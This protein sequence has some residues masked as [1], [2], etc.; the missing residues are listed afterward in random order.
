MYRPA[1]SS[2]RTI[3]LN[4][5]SSESTQ[6]C[7]VSTEQHH[8]LIKRLEKQEAQLQSTNLVTQIPSEGIISILSSICTDH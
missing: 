2:T 3:T 7:A 5:S 4:Q 8:M 1:A 6:E